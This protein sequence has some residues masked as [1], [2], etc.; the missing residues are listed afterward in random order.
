LRRNI[1]EVWQ[2]VIN[3]DLRWPATEVV[4]QV[5]WIKPVK[6]RRPRSATV[7]LPLGPAPM[8]GQ[9]AG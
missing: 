5:A 1:D 2:T 7:P 8:Q 4:E 3:S 9:F 6:P